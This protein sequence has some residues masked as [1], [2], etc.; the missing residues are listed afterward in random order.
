MPGTLG[1][2]EISAIVAKVAMIAITSNADTRRIASLAD[3][4]L[5]EAI[6]VDDDARARGI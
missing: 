3:L 5:V 1:A 6:H 2:Q 4:G